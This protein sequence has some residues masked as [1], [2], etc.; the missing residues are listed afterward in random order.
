MTCKGMIK[1]GRKRPRASNE[2]DLNLMMIYSGV[3]KL[4]EIFFLDLKRGQTTDL[5]S[6]AKNAQQEYVI[7]PNEEI[8]DVGSSWTLPN[9]RFRNRP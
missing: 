4:F 8:E 7:I 3:T 6:F 1:T 5:F 2:K 9:W